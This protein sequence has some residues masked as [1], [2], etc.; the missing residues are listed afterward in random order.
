MTDQ[1]PTD[2]VPLSWQWQQVACLDQQVLLN[3]GLDI[4]EERLAIAGD[5]SEQTIEAT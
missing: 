4:S 3:L 2:K 5:K 1:L